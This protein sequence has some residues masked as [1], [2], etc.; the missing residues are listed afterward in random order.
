[1]EKPKLQKVVDDFGKEMRRRGI[2][3]Y[4]VGIVRDIQNKPVIEI[5]VQRPEMYNNPEIISKIPKTFRE[6]KVHVA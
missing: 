4:V 2:P 5:V 1:M 3:F 6:I